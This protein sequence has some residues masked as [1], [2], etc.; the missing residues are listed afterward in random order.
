MTQSLPARLPFC[1]GSIGQEPSFVGFRLPNRCCE[2]GPADILARV[3]SLTVDAAA[4][5]RWPIAY[6][7]GLLQPDTAESR[8]H[9]ACSTR[10]AGIA[11]LLNQHVKPYSA[12]EAACPGQGS[13]SSRNQGA[14]ES[15]KEGA[16]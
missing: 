14:D 12:V 2:F 1:K 3:K 13:G 9:G 5:T 10:S 7:Q 4:S 8:A 6:S 11:T 15:C 16:A